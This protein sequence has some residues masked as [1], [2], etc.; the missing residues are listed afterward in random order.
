M[1]V[2]NNLKFKFLKEKSSAAAILIAYGQKA[3][4]SNYILMP[5]DTGEYKCVYIYIM[6]YTVYIIMYLWAAT[7]IYSPVYE[8]NPLYFNNFRYSKN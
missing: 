5:F 4:E 3:A 6:Q 2:A 7:T 8:S 1:K